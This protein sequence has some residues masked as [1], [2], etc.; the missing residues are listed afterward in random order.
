MEERAKHARLPLF[1]SHNPIHAKFNS[2]D[3]AYSTY[4]D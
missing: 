2:L 3:T 1:Y 4:R